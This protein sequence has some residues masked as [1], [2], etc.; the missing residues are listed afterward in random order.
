M[1]NIDLSDALNNNSAINNVRD[2]LNDI[3]FTNVKN[4]FSSYNPMANGN[5]GNADK[6]LNDL[7]NYL[8][9]SLND[10]SNYPLKQKIVD[11]TQ[12]ISNRNYFSD[13]NIHDINSK[14]KSA[15]NEFSAK[16]KS[17]TDQLTDAFNR[18]KERLVA[19]KNNV[20]SGGMYPYTDL[21]MIIDETH[22]WG[23]QMMEHALFLHLGLEATTIAQAIKFSEEM[24]NK[25][26]ID[27]ADF[28]MQA[29]NLYVE[30]KNFLT[31][32]F[33]GIDPNKIILSQADIDGI[34]RSNK[35]NKSI[36]LNLIKKTSDANQK[37]INILN[38]NIWM[39]WIF[40]SFAQHA[41]DE[42]EY[43]RRKV[44]GEPYSIEAEIKY[45][46]HHHSTELAATKQLVDPD[47][48]NDDLIMKIWDLS[49]GKLSGLNAN[50]VA[51]LQGMDSG[52]LQTM[53]NLSHR[54]SKEL[55][56]FA[57]DTGMKIDNKQLKSII[58]PV[59]AHHV[60]REFERF[61]YT[62]E[63]LGAK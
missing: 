52:E 13:T 11:K 39:G 61:Q 50:Q 16:L 44:A 48:I 9:N 31:D 34:K 10:V 45:I 30:W 23:N 38:T 53:L 14:L 47:P 19:R 36:V 33:F 59:L 18:F 58:H 29:Y 56:A 8:S 5:T 4:R 21:D 62:L 6:S 55:V 32:V 37:V 3:D 46:N 57:K 41:Q 40:P 35:I 24:C 49:K 54:Y 43:F 17:T 12:S 7:S 26:T 60:E 27:P 63:A 1:Y 25:G 2:N 42:T 28:K 15:G 20:Q 22:F 51:L